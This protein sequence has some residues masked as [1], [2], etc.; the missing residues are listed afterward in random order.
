MVYLAALLKGVGRY[1]SLQKSVNHFA[2]LTFSNC[3]L[4]TQCRPNLVASKGVRLLPS[5]HY[6]NRCGFTAFVLTMY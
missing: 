6:I 1:P 3:P 5:C 4:L 2:T